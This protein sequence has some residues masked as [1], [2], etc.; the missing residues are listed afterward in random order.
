[1]QFSKN[2]I[3][4]MFCW[5]G[6]AEKRLY[7]MTYQVGATEWNCS[8]QSLDY[9]PQFFSNKLFLMGNLFFPVLLYFIQSGESIYDL[10]QFGFILWHFPYNKWTHSKTS[11]V[12]F[13]DV[14]NPIWHLDG[15]D[16]K[17][18]VRTWSALSLIILCY[19]SLNT[20]HALLQY[21]WNK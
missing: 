5:V 13:I 19:H 4:L 2:D 7:F 1:M 10:T 12:P 20:F 11:L 6:L 15:S 18:L 16:W 17:S 14:S 21:P 9:F 8:K 3:K